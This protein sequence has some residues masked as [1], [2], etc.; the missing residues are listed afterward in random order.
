MNESSTTVLY[1][2]GFSPTLDQLE[3]IALKNIPVMYEVWVAEVRCDNKG[4]L[5]H[6]TPMIE[7]LMRFRLNDKG[8]LQ[9]CD[10]N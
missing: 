7:T 2:D 3:F 1:F 8:K 4:C 9:G 6:P 5:R 10:S